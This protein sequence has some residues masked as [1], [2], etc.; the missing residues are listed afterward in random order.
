[1]LCAALVA[2]FN[3]GAKDETGNDKDASDAIEKRAALFAQPFEAE[4]DAQFFIELTEEIEAEDR[5]AVR[6]QWLCNLADRA[7]RVLRSAFDA[8]PR[9]GQLRYRAQS[10]ALGRLHGQM[11]SDKSKLPALAQALKTRYLT[12]SRSTREENHEHA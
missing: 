10:A 2:L 9:S 8:G 11:R 5:D 1:M 4:C 6:K 3:S 7:E 12:P